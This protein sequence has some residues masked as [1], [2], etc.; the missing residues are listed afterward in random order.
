MQKQP[1]AVNPAAL[2]IRPPEPSELDWLVDMQLRM[3]LETENLHL[4]RPTV[5]RGVRAVFD[6]PAK[7]RYL[8]AEMDGRPVGCLLTLGEWSDWRNGTVL[9]I[10]SVY[11]LPEYRGRGVYRAMYEHLKGKVQTDPALKGLRLYV[12]RNNKPAQ[13]AYEKL[14]MNGEHYRLYEW[15]K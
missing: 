8:T 6:D 13:S 9:W 1:N 4:D 5:T 12:D 15:M 14:G 7:G 10:H 3:A 11:V 2:T